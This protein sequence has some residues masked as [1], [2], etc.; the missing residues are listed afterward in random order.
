MILQ[1]SVT[2]DT[3]LL[4]AVP[5]LTRGGSVADVGTDHA[6]LP[7]YLVQEGIVSHALAC[8]INEGPILSA[9][10][11]I[12]EA[13]L[14]DRIDTLQTD[15]LHGV[16]AYSPDN[17]MIFGMGGE[18]IARI[19]S[20]APWIK[21]ESVGLI[22]QPMSRVSVLREWLLKNG[23]AIVGETVTFEDKYYQTVCARYCGERS[24]YSA[25][26]LQVGRLNISNRPPHFEGLVR[27]E[28]AVLDAIIRGK[29]RSE[30]ADVAEE[31]RLKQDLEELL[32]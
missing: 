23:F 27:H 19:L 32:S 16:E 7:I 15:G 28:I 18:L 4:S 25:V 20:E 8:D 24:S 9:R 2:P 5:Y 12:A 26:E 10:K 31:L 1:L 21:R 29:S 17:I 13:G 22:L 14:L 30:S 3:R 6:Y 11:N